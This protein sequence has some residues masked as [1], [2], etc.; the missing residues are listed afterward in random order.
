MTCHGADFEYQ[1]YLTQ[2]GDDRAFKVWSNVVMSVDKTGEWWVGDQPSD[3]REF[4]EAYTSDGYRVDEFRLSQCECGSSE[5]LLSADDDEGCARRQCWS[6]K[7]S[8]FIC[9]SEQY[10]QEAKPVTWNC[11]ERRSKAR[12]CNIGVGFS[13]YEDGE[14]RW[15]YVGLR[16]MEGR[17][18][19]VTST[20]GPSVM[21]GRLHGYWKPALQAIDSAKENLVANLH[22]GSSYQGLLSPPGTWRPL[23]HPVPRPSPDPGADAP[24]RRR[25]AAARTAPR[26][27][28]TAA[29]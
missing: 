13:P 26:P 28:S 15:L 29:R 25:S 7:Q 20:T 5:F 21:V 2:P 27:H 18:L 1:L 17:L 22:P 12:A 6:C 4:L 8:K 19:T 23:F 10:W 24:G 9:D 14:V 11:M 16:R 3:I